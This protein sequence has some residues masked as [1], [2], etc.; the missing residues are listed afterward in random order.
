MRITTTSTTKALSIAA[1]ALLGLTGCP[2]D[3][4]SVDTEGDTET[5]TTTSTTAPTG[6]TTVADTTVADTTA[7]DTTAT[8]TTDGTSTTGP[9]QGLL[10][11]VVEALG[12]EAALAGLTG[13]ELQVSGERSITD[14]SFNPGDP[15]VVV[16]NFQTTVSIDFQN[17]GVRNDISRN[18]LYF[19]IPG[20][21]EITEWAV[22]EG[23]YVGGIESAFGFPTGTMLSD[24]WASTLKQAVVLNPH[25]LVLGALEDP[26][27]A[28]EAGTGD[29]EGQTYD[30]LEIADDVSPLTLW[31]DQETDLVRRLTTT[32][33]SH[34]RRDVQLEVVYG[35]WEETADGV[36]FPN[37]VQLLVDGE[38]FHDESRD[39]VISNPEFDPDTFMLPPE[40][41]PMLDP[42]EAFRGLR[43]SQQ[44]QAFAALGV[45]LDGLQTFVLAAEIA[46]GVHHLTGGS[47]N[48]LVV[49]Q[50]GGVVVFDAPLTA[51]RCEAILDWI[52]SDLGGAPVTHIVQSHHHTDHASCART[53]VAVGA[54]LVVH[55]ASESFFADILA[56]PSTIEPDRLEQMPVMDPIIEVVPTGGSFLIDD[57]TNPVEVFELVSTHAADMVLPF[58]TSSG[59][60]F[61]VD[62][63]NP[64]TGTF[65]PSGPQEVLATLNTYMIYGSVQQ[66]AGGHGGVGTLAE[67]EMAAGG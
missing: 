47:H 26:G 49:E 25:I 14:E 27:T 50:E 33:N 20:P 13:V 63:F 66:I 60:A 2:G 19:P 21:L 58:V 16:S 43:N 64:G 46:P 1:L 65:D 3:D 51:E 61:T 35:D 39:V 32:E 11:R 44:S 18:L 59:V 12:G 52:D 29:F 36:L 31:V 22:A 56:A 53:F 57:A 34:L 45:P 9:E 7:T 6:P 5:G 24:R 17:G 8:D 15:S 38:V 4:T 54:T 62:V 41:D 40:A 28:S 30:L 23:G 10:E 48:S 42:L 37:N 67:L 55:E